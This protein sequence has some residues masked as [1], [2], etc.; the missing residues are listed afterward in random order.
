MSKNISVGGKSYQVS[1]E[2]EEKINEFMEDEEDEVEEI[3]Q[4]EDLIGKKFLFQC[5]R[6]IY[7]GK[8]KSINSVYIELEDASVVFET[9][10]Y[11]QKEATNKQETPHNIHIMRNAIESF[12]A[13]RW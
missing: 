7:H 5:A 13:L 11:N 2:V 8:V 9:G 1:E 6:Y 10:D 3:E 4:L 12:Y